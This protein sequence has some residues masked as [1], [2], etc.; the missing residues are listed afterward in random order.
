MKVSV[1]KINL[2]VL[3]NEYEELLKLLQR[4]EFMM[5]ESN[6]N[7]NKTID[8]SYYDELIARVNQTIKY[9]ETFRLKRKFFNYKETTYDVFD[10]R[11]GGYLKLLKTL[12]VLEERENSQLV[13]IEELNKEINVYA[14]F[15]KSELNLENMSYTRYIDFY[16][17]FID[18]KKQ[19]ELEDFFLAN[20]I[21]H[22]FYDKDKRGIA[23]TFAVLKEEKQIFVQEIKRLDFK[24]VKMPVYDGV[25]SEYLDNLEIKKTKQEVLLKET[26]KEIASFLPKIND[27]Y[28]YADQIASDKSRKQISYEIH[29]EELNIVKITGWIKIKREKELKKL[30]NNNK[31]NFELEN[32]TQKTDEIVPA[33]LENN[34]FVEPF[35]VITE[36]FSAPSET[37]L[38]PNPSMSIW[39]F[40]IFGIMMGDVGYG[41]LLI[42]GL[43]L[44]LKLLKPKGG[45]RKLMT[46]LYYGGYS[47]VLFGVLHGSFFGFDFDL[48]YLIGSLFKQNWTTVL[49][50]PVED[51][52]KMLIYALVL[53]FVQIS[54]GL[55]LKS[56]RLFKLKNWQGAIGEAI[57]N[58]LIL[59]GLALIALT[60]V[61][62]N[63]NI[64]FG[65]SV[66]IL[67]V[68]LILIFAGNEKGIGGAIAGKLGGLYGIINQLSDILSYSRI[69]A[70]ALST[71]IIALTFNT[72]AGMFAGG[73]IGIFVAILIYIIGHTFN[74]AMGLLST[75]IHDSRLQYVEFFGQ[76][77][78]G[79]GKYFTPLR[80]ELNHLNE[81]INNRDFGGNKI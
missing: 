1:K 25:I 40:I 65:L 66:I 17:G 48:G 2:Y 68:L 77:F 79:G 43:G 33:A 50:D 70:L 20:K 6:K 80:L 51:A 29:S 30:L 61:L 44:A 15:T 52:L 55:I 22:N 56:V 8:V 10:D 46:V 38:D 28:I 32:A 18:E 4:N 41:L 45:M 47:T 53:G 49:L 72:L 34:K 78:D 26:E 63:F 74:L 58:L 60:F 81:V 71:A 69:L 9:L 23:T 14:P 37:D 35:E 75:Y 59:L 21:S 16:H 13:K 42:L 27:L 76:F 7:S 36:Q 39:Y 64:W 31:F 62:S 67:G 5:I 57:G 12:E 19:K 73:L 3:K 11:S 54:H 24:E